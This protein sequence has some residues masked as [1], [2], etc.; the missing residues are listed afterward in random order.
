MER[1]VIGE[2]HIRIIPVLLSLGSQ[3]VSLLHHFT[4]ILENEGFQVERNPDT[5]QITLRWQGEAGKSYTIQSSPTMTC[6]FDL[7][8]RPGMDGE[9]TVSFFPVGFPKSEYYRILAFD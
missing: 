9:M 4:E 8:F 3:L 1:H 2:T 7:D 5:G 6:W